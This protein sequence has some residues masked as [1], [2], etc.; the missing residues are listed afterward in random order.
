MATPRAIMES[1]EHGGNFCMND[2]FFLTEADPLAEGDT[3]SAADWLML[4]KKLLTSWVLI[5]LFV[6]IV[7]LTSYWKW[8]RVAQYVYLFIAYQFFLIDIR[9]AHFLFR[10][11]NPID[12]DCH[13][14]FN[15]LT[16][17]FVLRYILLFLRRWMFR[18]V[19]LVSLS[20]NQFT[21]GSFGVGRFVWSLCRILLNMYFQKQSNTS[22]S[23]ACE[24]LFIF[25]SFYWLLK[26]S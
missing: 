24:S 26:K 25:F 1:I 2:F 4:K 17:L 10:P 9:L 12:V 16:H 22:Q 19:G 23:N 8:H 11:W 14:V 3:C 15:F 7:M 21:Y 13:I 20:R 5:L 18:A 6:C